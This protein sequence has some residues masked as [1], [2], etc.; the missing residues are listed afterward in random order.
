MKKDFTYDMTKM[1]RAQV[2]I[3]ILLFSYLMGLIVLT[4]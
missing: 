2:A 4:Y 1:N 3:I